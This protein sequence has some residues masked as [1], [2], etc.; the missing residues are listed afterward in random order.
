MSINN[1]Y[2]IKEHEGKW[3]GWDEM[4]EQSVNDKPDRVLHFSEARFVAD[5]KHQLEDMMARDY[6]LSPEYGYATDELPKDGT[7]VRFEK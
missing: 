6:Y 7:K 2:I 3:Y 4:A 1:V 5:T